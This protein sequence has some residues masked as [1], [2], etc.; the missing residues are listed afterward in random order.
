MQSVDQ[1]AAFRGQVAANGRLNVF[2]ALQVITNAALPAAV[3]GRFPASSLTHQDAPIE[4]WF[5][6]PMERASVEAALQLTPAVTG[7]FEWSDGDRLVRLVPSTP[8]LRTNYF[9]RLLGTA[10]D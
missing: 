3:V 6:R 9:A 4:L 2:R 5:N 10:H 8:L 1:G 7:V